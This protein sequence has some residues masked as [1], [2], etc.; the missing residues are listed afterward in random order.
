MIK[1]LFINYNK[2]KIK[3]NIYR[4]ST[5]LGRAHDIILELLQA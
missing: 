3:L 1:K 4:T 5:A 2:L